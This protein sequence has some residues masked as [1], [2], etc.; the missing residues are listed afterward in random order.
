MTT[1]IQHPEIG[2]IRLCS[3]SNVRRRIIRVTVSSV[4]ITVPIGYESS[5]FPLSESMVR[6]ILS[7]QRKIKA[8]VNVTTQFQI[9]VPI[10]TLA[11]DIIVKRQ[12]RCD[13]CV[14]SAGLDNNILTVFIPYSSD[15]C[16][17]SV[18]AAI[19]RIVHKFLLREAWRI[20][21]GKVDCLS[22]KYNMPYRSLKIDSTR[23]RWGCCSSERNIKLSCFLLLL[24]ERI[25]DY[26]IVHEL[27]HTKEMNHGPRFK[28][29]LHGFF[30]DYKIIELEKSEWDRKVY[31]IK[32]K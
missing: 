7:M 19:R 21:P 17:S 8:E 12:M 16:S 25:V 28:R 23:S 29:L 4:T 13:I 14:F 24:P 18:Q 32:E 11:F 9:D 1:T 3:R 6:D 10:K 20:L 30:D 15:I 5:V 27:C 26:I 31:W 2:L 22:C